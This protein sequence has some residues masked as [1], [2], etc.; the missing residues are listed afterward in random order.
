MTSVHIRLQPFALIVPA[1]LLLLTGCEG[2][3]PMDIPDAVVE[4]FS[5][6]GITLDED[7]TPQEVVFVLT[8]AIHDDVKGAQADDHTR[9]KEAV[10]LQFRLAAYS[11]IERRLLQAMKSADGPEIKSLG[12]DR[13]EDLYL[14]VQQWGSIL[15]HYVDGFQNTFQEASDRMGVEPKSVSRV[16]VTYEVEAN[17]DAATEEDR[18]PATLEFEVVEEKADGKGYWRVAKVDFA[19]P[20][21]DSETSDKSIQLD[22]EE[23]LDLP[24][25]SDP[26]GPPPSEAPT[27]PAE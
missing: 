17:P 2:R 21:L 19:G 9:H 5:A 26:E 6:H 25:A 8:R 18:Q 14:V 3:E 24:D 7:A 1:M 10:D 13:A 16:L 20:E 4:P 22:V 12:D 23:L 15:G 11:V 27:L